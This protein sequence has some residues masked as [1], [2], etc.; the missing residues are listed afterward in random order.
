MSGTQV[1]QN[2]MKTCEVKRRIPQQ[3][4][5]MIDSPTSTPSTTESK[6]LPI[7]N[8]QYVKECRSSTPE[9]K[10]FPIGNGKYVKVC[11]RRRKLCVNIRDYTVNVKGQLYATNRGILLSPEE[12][13]RFKSIIN[14][15]DQ[16]LLETN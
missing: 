2:I 4:S 10:I 9:P 16:E 3:R 15:V 12:W 11:L 14:D 1:R 13:E 5:V 6:I 8:G 7:G